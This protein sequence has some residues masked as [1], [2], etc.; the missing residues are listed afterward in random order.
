MVCALFCSAC[1]QWCAVHTG[2]FTKSDYEQS[3]AYDPTLLQCSCSWETADINF[4]ELFTETRLSKTWVSRQNGTTAAH[5]FYTSVPSCGG[6]FTFS[7]IGWKTMD[8]KSTSTLG[9][10][11]RQHLNHCTVYHAPRP[12]GYGWN[13]KRKAPG[14]HRTA[15]SAGYFAHP[16]LFHGSRLHLRWCYH[17]HVFPLQRCHLSLGQGRW[18]LQDSNKASK[19][20]C[21]S[22]KGQHTKL[23]SRD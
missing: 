14:I 4:P 22:E 12:A 5:L 3:C 1:S 23:F 10:K 7:S 19:S 15:E 6:A 13:M 18:V 2:A 20:D 9:F 17:C 11:L 16:D 21:E 8:S